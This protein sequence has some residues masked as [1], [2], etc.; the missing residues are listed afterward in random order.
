[1]FAFDGK[2]I[3]KLTE[4]CWWFFKNIVL[5]LT[6]TTCTSETQPT[7]SEWT[8]LLCKIKKVLFLAYLFPQSEEQEMHSV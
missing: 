1:M 8:L 7:Q 6:E 5:V 3:D 2:K 4:T